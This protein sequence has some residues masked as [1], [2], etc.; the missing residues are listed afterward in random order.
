MTT[1]QNPY[2]P[3]QRAGMDEPRPY[4]N[5][6]SRQNRHIITACIVAFIVICGF[7][8]IPPVQAWFGVGIGAYLVQLF[9]RLALIALLAIGARASLR[10]AALPGKKT[11]AMVERVVAA[12]LIIAAVVW[13]VFVAATYGA[14]VPY[15]AHP[16]EVTLVRGFVSGSG[17]ERQSVEDEG[18]IDYYLKGFD[19]ENNYY[20]F[21]ITGQ[22]YHAHRKDGYFH[23]TYLPHTRILMS[24][25][26]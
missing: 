15:L 11:T 10:D 24:L 25:S 22:V 16:K 26:S 7:S 3:V 2:P 6:A 19:A 12:G 4:E 17:D 5:R 23:V 13:L 9:K 18:E 21:P 14:D 20:E 1:S 8:V